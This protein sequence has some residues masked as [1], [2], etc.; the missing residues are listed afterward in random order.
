MIW[1]ES[2]MD[3]DI[4]HTIEYA[5]LHR[6]LG[7]KSRT[8]LRFFPSLK[9]TQAFRRVPI[10][11]LAFFNIKPQLAQ[12][13]R[14]I[15]ARIEKKPDTLLKYVRSARAYILPIIIFRVSDWDR[16]VIPRMDNCRDFFLGYEVIIQ[17]AFNNRY[18]RRN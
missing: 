6:C 9:A 15:H 10:K 11:P 14:P 13:P 3:A 4:F 8:T 5:L 12:K 2:A 1:L 17:H 7:I 18:N 16:E